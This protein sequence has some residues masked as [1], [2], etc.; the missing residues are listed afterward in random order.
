MKLEKFKKQYHLL[1]SMFYVNMK[2]YVE[3]MPYYELDFKRR[4]M[5][6][7]VTAKE[8]LLGYDLNLNTNDNY[9]HDSANS[10]QNNPNPPTNT[11]TKCYYKQYL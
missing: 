10:L 6:R 7:N 3:L 2:D 11:K 5:I 8:Q 1:K 9:P 4:L